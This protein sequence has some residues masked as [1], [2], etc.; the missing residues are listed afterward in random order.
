M[1][2]IKRIISLPSSFKIE[3]NRI[4]QNEKIG[5]TC[6]REKTTE[7]EWIITEQ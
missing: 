7:P 1:L 5:K 3:E 4:L 2:D 6:K